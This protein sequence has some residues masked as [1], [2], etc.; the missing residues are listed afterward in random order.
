VQS[1]PLILKG[2]L[3]L[4][5][6]GQAGLGVEPGGSPLDG[7][8]V[9]QTAQPQQP[10]Q[11]D[12]PAA[13]ESPMPTQVAP[14]SGDLPLGY[15]GV[16]LNLLSAERRDRAET[17]TA[18]LV[19]GVESEL[20][21]STDAG[22]LL[23]KSQASTGIEVQRRSPIA[24]DP[25]VR[26]YRV[27][28]ILTQLDGASYS[29][30]RSDLDTM[31]SKVDSGIIRDIIVLKAPHSARYGPGFSFIDVETTATPRYESGD[32]WHGRT[33]LNY[34]TNGEQ[35]YGRQSVWGG[36][37]DWGVRAE[38]GHR[39]GSDYETGDDFE[40]P[41]SYKSRD[42]NV[43]IGYDLSCDSRIEFGYLRLDQ[44]DVEFPGLV[45]DIDFL[46]TDGYNVRYLIED[47]CSFDRFTVDAWYNRTRFEGNAQRSGKRKQIPELD[48][49]LFGDLDGDGLNDVPGVAVTDVDQ[50]SAGFRA[51]L[52][53][54]FADQPQLTLGVDLRRVGM[55]LNDIEPLRPAAEQNF[56]IPDSHA[57]NPGLFVEHTLP[58]TD[59]LKFK[60]GG[61]V[62][63]VGANAR[64][65]VDGV[66]DP[67][68]T[69]LGAGL[70][71]HFVLW[72]A[73]ATAEYEL[74]DCWTATGGLAFAQRPPTLTE[75]YA[76]GSFIGVLKPGLSSVSGDPELDP[77][78]LRQIDLG[79]QAEYDDFRGRLTGFYSWIDDYI[80]FD[81]RLNDPADPD[82]GF[83][84]Q[85]TNTPLATLAGFELM[86]EYDV[87]PQWTGFALMSYV[88]GR[89]RSRVTPSPFFPPP[90]S[91]FAGAEHEPLPGIP[92]LETRLGLRYHDPSPNPRW[93]VELAA[94]IVDN[95]DRLAVSLGELE[96]PGFTTWDL[97]A[98]WQAV[99]S[100][101][102]VAGVENFTDKFY[103]EHLDLRP[104]R[105]V[106]Q[107]GV[108]F[109]FGFELSY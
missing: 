66:P 32:Q 31:L 27:G 25:R 41:S 12:P 40:I 43:M 108:N 86:A 69:L 72:S 15:R 103:R 107:P 45:F 75:L 70:E 39:T 99:D 95:Q 68:S 94:R 90:R 71:Q 6:V 77:E 63:W 14:T 19:A 47:Q 28:Q 59:R 54:G 11:S 102:L 64:D 53:W 48:D 91:A 80:T 81:E 46:V 4:A 82:S 21:S 83:F 7:N 3:G 96:T 98:Y 22:S 105:G 1:R 60:S 2:L 101:L 18:T 109:Y 57:A 89:D 42:A 9:A 16:D 23:G 49:A 73:F 51:A 38:Y 78:R 10:T 92:P 56:P 13:G 84:Q 5:L 79:I 17:P 67:I 106:F 55:E 36:S 85:F 20:R 34:Q 97:R 30:A 24:N 100:L 37:T 52:T 33:S 74:S 65:H 26:G 104:G 8:E 50:S 61:R 76:V 62:D 88:E 58:W 35:W 44:T 29:P 93:G 87:N